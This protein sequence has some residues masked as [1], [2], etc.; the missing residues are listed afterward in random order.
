MNE[1]YTAT[2]NRCIEEQELAHTF[3]RSAAYYCRAGMFGN[4]IQMQREA[5]Y[6]HAEAS[7]RLARLIGVE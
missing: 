3:A 6:H 2:A 5:A 4:A 1:I 7:M